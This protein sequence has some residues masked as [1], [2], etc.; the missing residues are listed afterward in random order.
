MRG[1]TQKPYPAL[2]ITALT[3]LVPAALVVLLSVV[4]GLIGLATDE[5]L[6][7]LTIGAF[8]LCVALLGAVV[9][10]VRG[11]L[12]ARTTEGGSPA[13]PALGAGGALVLAGC[14]AFAGLLLGEDTPDWLPGGPSILEEAMEEC[15]Y[16]EENL[17]GIT[18]DED[19]DVITVSSAGIQNDGVPTAEGMEVFANYLCIEDAVGVPQYVRDEISS[20]TSLQGRQEAEWDGLSASWSYHPNNGLNITFRMAE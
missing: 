12:L 17:A 7:A 11:I 3:L 2:F 20:T 18:F 6:G 8:A 15:G 9:Y 10:F 14:V 4:M 13:L 16:P 5:D 1:I 19:H